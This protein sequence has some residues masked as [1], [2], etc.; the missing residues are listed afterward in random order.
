LLFTGKEPT[1]YIVVSHIAEA[2]WLDARNRNMDQSGTIF[3]TPRPEAGSETATLTETW[4]GDLRLSA[5]TSQATVRK[6][7]TAGET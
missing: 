7:I 4:R 1:T 6:K 3:L 2:Y 5:E